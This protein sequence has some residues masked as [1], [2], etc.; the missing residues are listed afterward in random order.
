MTRTT[1]SLILI[2]LGV[3][4]LALAAAA[5][6]QP[7]REFGEE[8]EVTEVL[9]DVLVTDR[10]GNV[11]IG[12]DA[13]DFIVKEEGESVDLTSA[14]FYSNRR[15]LDAEGEG[16]A[17]LAELPADRYFIL[18]FHDQR[19]QLPS[20]IN[21]QLEA[22]RWT[23]RWV[24]EE[25]LA[26]DYIAVVSYDVKLKVQQDFTNDKEAII[27]G[28]DN[29]IKRKDLGG[30]WPSRQEATNRPSLLRNLP[31][32]KE[33]RRQTRNVHQGLQLVGEA[34]GDVVGRKNLMLFSIGFG[35]VD[36][37]GTYSPDPRYYKKM[38]Q[39][40]NDSNVA[41]Y[42][43][44]LVP[45]SEGGTAFSRGLNDS[46]SSLADDTGGR[47]YLNF[48]TFRTP[49]LQVT[50]ET[51]GYYLL[52]YSSRYPVGTSGFRDVVVQA[53]NPEFKVRARKGYRYGI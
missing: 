9:L 41:V 4:G 48:N 18:F 43:I 44:D 1:T 22:A 35:E 33:L 23:K 20:L 45:S 53:R 36:E 8:L 14:T 31:K 29:A 51:N 42:A 5:G 47:Y 26:N 49:L 28:I 32:G 46:L 2:F 6:A 15:Y 30:E 52:S 40:F 12:L 16:E 7:T 50:E 34:L 24:R 27:T 19:Q 21:Q 37:F 25:A 11:I 17:A 3:L 39:A 13:D 38:M 10:K